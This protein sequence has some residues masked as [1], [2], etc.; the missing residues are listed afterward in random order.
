MTRV[1]VLL[2]LPGLSSQPQ[3]PLGGPLAAF[4]Q[5]RAQ[6]TSADVVG[7]PMRAGD[8]TVIPFAA[9]RMAPG[10]APPKPR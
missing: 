8:V 6:L 4:D 1:F 5:L 3:T 9:S 2:A 10:T 7:E